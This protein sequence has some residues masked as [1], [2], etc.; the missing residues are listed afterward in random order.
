MTDE[1]S[2]GWLA[3]TD[4]V[5]ERVRSTPSSRRLALLTASIVG[6]GLSLVHWVGLVVGGALVGL[7]R[8]RLRGAVLV[9][10][11]F[12]LLTV[13]LTVLLGGP[14]LMSVLRPVSYGTAAVGIMLPVWGSLVRYAL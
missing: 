10:A 12:G 9:G 5:V 2:E 11:G 4:A 8:P 7:T 3:G 13:A 1:R 6:I 14:E